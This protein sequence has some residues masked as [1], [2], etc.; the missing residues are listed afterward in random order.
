[1]ARMMTSIART[2]WILP[3]AASLLSA[4]GCADG[5]VPEVRSLNPWL[6]K[7]WAED[8][9]A[10]PTYHRKVADLAKLRSRVRN[11]TPAELE[12]AASELSQRLRDEPSPVMRAELVRTLGEL[13][14]AAART[15]VLG[16]ASDESPHVR[17]AACKA[18]S[19]Q[20][21]PEGFES[22]SQA[23]AGDSDMDVRIAAAR[24]LG[25]FQQF[26]S[27]PALRPALD[28]NDP[29]LQLAAMQSLQ[30]VTGR[31]EY[32]TDHRWVATWREYLGGGTP[33]PPP[34][35]TL[36]ELL[37]QYRYWF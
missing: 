6:R 14:S 19:R 13:P 12:Q 32:G 35:P 9:L 4:A 8:E 30:S 3:L 10:G 37:Q 20:P 26:E 28:D 1:M 25:Q 27:A 23:V 18:L 2:L 34:A 5:I 36:A 22:L 7:Q 11:L 33:T 24:S 29:A 31:S 21:T 15:A 17:I 16:A